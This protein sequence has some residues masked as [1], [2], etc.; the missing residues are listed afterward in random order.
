MKKKHIIHT[1]ITLVISLIKYYSPGSS[2]QG[3]EEDHIAGY[4]LE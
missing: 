3:M 2:V 4:I 1:F